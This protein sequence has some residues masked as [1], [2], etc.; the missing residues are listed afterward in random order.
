MCVVGLYSTT[1]KIEE[2]IKCKQQ[3]KNMFY[4]DYQFVSHCGRKKNV[5][6]HKL[7]QMR[8]L[9]NYFNP[10]VLSIFNPPLI[11]CVIDPR[12]F[13]VVNFFLSHC[14]DFFFF[15]IIII[16]SSCVMCDKDE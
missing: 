9:V 2:I 10:M 8:R 7:I 16:N 3:H 12:L 13:A 6:V 4:F 5:E 15:N 14:V 11:S 1:T